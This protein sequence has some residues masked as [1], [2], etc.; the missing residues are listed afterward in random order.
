MSYKCT[1]CSNIEPNYN[2]IW[3]HFIYDH[4]DVDIVTIDNN[5]I[6]QELIN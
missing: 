6:K 1:I 2:R 4:V 5:T 3:D